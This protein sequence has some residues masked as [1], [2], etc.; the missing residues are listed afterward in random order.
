MKILIATDLYLPLVNGVVT[1]VINLKKELIKRGHEV[2]VLTLSQKNSNNNEDDVWY[3]PSIGAGSVY[4]QARVIRTLPIRIIKEIVHWSPDII[5]TQC[6]FSTF[7]IAKRI[8]KKLNIPL[9]HTYHTVYEDYTHYFINS[10]YIGK[11]VVAKF[12]NYILSGTKAVIAPTEKVRD[13][14]E[15]YNVEKPIYTVPSGISIDEVSKRAP[16]KETD[17]L[18]KSFNIP[19]DKKVLLYLGRLAKEKNISE[20][21]K[22]YKKADL[23]DG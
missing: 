1:S 2:K 6:E 15:K 8:S 18:K 14:L 17:K 5:H 23:S 20:L 16:K 19:E 22:F 3:L 13:I 21:I 7:F 9:I 11:R 4:P 12:S 10:E